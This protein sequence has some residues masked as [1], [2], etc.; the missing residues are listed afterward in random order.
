MT[1]LRKT[2]ISLYLSVFMS[3]LGLGILSPILPAYVDRFAASSLILGLV[4]GTYSASRTIFMPMV[5]NL[6]DRLGRRYFIFAG[7]ALFTLVS[8]LYALAGDAVQLMLVRFIQGIAAAMLL[9]VAMSA[10]GDLSPRGREGFI[11]GSFTSAF[12]AGLGFGPLIGGFLRDRYSMNAAFFGMGGLSLMALVF[13][14]ITLRSEPPRSGMDQRPD[15]G[16]GERSI[17][18]DSRLLG[19]L[20]FRFGRALGI[21]VVWV[22]MPLYAITRLGISAF[23]VGVLL[24]TNTFL[25]TLLQSPLGHLSDRIGHRKSLTAGSLIAAAAT[26]AIGWSTR[27]DQLILISLALG[28]SGALIVPSGTALAVSLGREMGMGT[29]MGLYNASLSLGT[30]LGPVA[31][32]GLLDLSG[33]RIVFQGGA[34]VGILG[35]LILLMTFPAARD[36]VWTGDTDHP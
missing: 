10:I 33:I 16:H 35:W 20:L 5:G 2:F 27:F 3:S 12:F 34:V 1:H 30:M 23:Q 19:L 9:P 6:S 22:I 18:L 4:F 24:S 28:L 7:L 21:G 17:L 32:G 26:A 36:P 11:M 29:V 31:G 8:P 15:R 14:V 13:S 25:T